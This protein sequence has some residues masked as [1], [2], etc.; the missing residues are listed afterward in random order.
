M[1]AFF[2]S[3]LASNNSETN[4]LNFL[5]HH[6]VADELQNEAIIDYCKIAPRLTT[7]LHSS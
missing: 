2:V 3:T 1:R 7:R 6:D 5:D 4:A